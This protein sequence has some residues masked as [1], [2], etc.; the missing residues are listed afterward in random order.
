MTKSAK[1]IY[2]LEG[3]IAH[4]GASAYVPE[5]TIEAFQ[6]AYDL[7]CR[8]IEFD[9][10]LNG[11]GE[12]FVFHDENLHR[13]TGSK[14]SIS[15]ASSAYLKSLEAG[16]W[17]KKEFHGA[18]IPTLSETLLWLRE[19]DMHANIEIKPYPGFE[20]ET[21]EVAINEIYKYWPKN[22]H[23]PLLSS[24]NMGVMKMCKNLAPEIPR[25]LLFDKWNDDWLNYARDIDCVS[26]N[27]NRFVTTKRRV[28]LIKQHN[29][30][31]CVY[32]VNR[33]TTA[34]KLFSYGVDAIFSNHPD[35][36]SKS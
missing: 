1:I 21:T 19:N 34:K 27:L 29:Y 30:K 15:E 13:T 18:K 25:G 6:H 17:F 26:I 33:Y 22:K 5:N 7:G 4:R 8:I 9:V 16:S 10:V 3:V 31:V 20:K 35:L 14:L 24:F 12:A 32:T 11:E 28:D 2:E 23:L 36:L